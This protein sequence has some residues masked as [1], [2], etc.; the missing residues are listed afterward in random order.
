MTDI[1]LLGP[2]KERILSRLRDGR[3]TAREVASDLGIQTSAAR[4]H[5]ERLVEMGTVREEFV[6]GA[7][8]RPK[9]YYAITDAGAELF[10]RHYDVVLNEVLARLEADGGAESAR[11]VITGVA[12]NFARPVSSRPGRPRLARALRLLND[13]GFE[14]TAERRGRKLV[15]TSRNCPILRTARRHRELVCGGLHAEVIR[16]AL[17][18][19]RVDRGKWI[20]DGDSVC[21]HTIET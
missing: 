21:T 6:R 4:K 12:E 13:L 2:A 16:R 15:I 5:L 18:V 20:V 3:Q 17:A 1:R 9:K 19:K 10:P 11:R 8:G 14:A 7:R